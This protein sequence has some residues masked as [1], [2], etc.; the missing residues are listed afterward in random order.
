MLKRLRHVVHHHLGGPEE[1]TLFEQELGDAVM[2]NGKIALLVFARTGDVAAGLV[3]L[4]E[5]GK[6]RVTS[7]TNLGVARFHNK[8]AVGLALQ[9]YGVG[10]ALITA[11]F[12]SDSG[13]ACVR[14]CC[15]LHRQGVCGLASP[16]LTQGG[17]GWCVCVAGKKRLDR[18][19]EDAWRT[20]HT[21]RLGGDVEDFDVHH[22]HHFVI[23]LGDLNYRCD[24]FCD[25]VREGRAG[26]GRGDTHTL[27]AY[28]SSSHARALNGGRHSGGVLCRR[29]Y[30]TLHY[31]TSLS[32]L[33]QVLG[34]IAASSE[35]EKRQRAQ[36]GRR[37]PELSWREESYARLFVDYAQLSRAR[38]SASLSGSQGGK[39]T[40]EAGGVAGDPTWQWAREL[41]ELSLSMASGLVFSSFQEGSLAFPPTF[42]MHPGRTVEDYADVEDLRYGYMLVKGQ[43]ASTAAGALK[44]LRPPSWSDRVLF[45]S[46][47]EC[48]HRLTLEAY[49][50]CAAMSG[51]DHRPVVASF[52]LDVSQAAQAAMSMTGGGVSMGMPSEEAPDRPPL[53][54]EPS[55]GFGSGALGLSG[56]ES[57]DDTP[58]EGADG[59]KVE[60][61]PDVLLGLDLQLQGQGQGQ[62]QPPGS[63]PP[64]PPRLPAPPPPPGLPDASSQ[65]TTTSSSNNNNAALAGLRLLSVKLVDFRFNTES[66]RTPMPLA[67]P[68][69]PGGAGGVS[70]SLGG[71]S[72]PPPSL[73]RGCTSSNSL[74]SSQPP[75]VASQPHAAAADFMYQPGPWLPCSSVSQEDVHEV[76][77]LLPIPCEDPLL[78][79]RRV[80]L[81]GQHTGSHSGPSGASPGH[82][83]VGAS[84]MEGQEHVHRFAWQDVRCVGGLKLSATVLPAA[85]MHAAIKFVDRGGANL[86]EGVF[87]INEALAK[88]PVAWRG[89]PSEGKRDLPPAAQRELPPGPAAH[90][91]KVQ[92]SL[93]GVACGEVSFGLM[94][95]KRRAVISVV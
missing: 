39:G 90:P 79:H 38:L 78:S 2:G 45:H 30:R 86:G 49:D 41:D 65:A 18:R 80:V 64:R 54:V 21:L 28:L 44:D 12:A 81:L 68:P 83:A 48:R 37:I 55:A 91:V 35:A 11:H 24:A 23:L 10:L 47:P 93:G 63:R 25:E 20:L 60:D 43:E 5:A 19:N 50:M 17:L 27:P 16:R 3:K 34:K 70:V 7:G 74:A 6:G 51:S 42:K 62:G 84:A 85:S 15:R 67:P 87:S 69:L 89:L 75:P 73:M 71:F 40:S 31:L 66:S 76:V 36:E 32:S 53:T 56:G 57:S 58:G 59:E 95:R 9:Y 72:M 13:G 1:F 94:V 46:L 8:G 82:G 4:N 29:P 26:Q 33:R 61:Q 52:L 22:Q 77:V 14:A 92:L 88:E